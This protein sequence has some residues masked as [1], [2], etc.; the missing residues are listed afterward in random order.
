MRGFLTSFDNHDKKS[1][2]Y[3]H[4][5]DEMKSCAFLTSSHISTQLHYKKQKQKQK[6][7]KQQQK[8]PKKHNPPPINNE[9][10]VYF[11]IW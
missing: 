6:Q 10:Q 11:N 7:K 1:K 9:L 4:L 5:T 8:N 3:L 2:P